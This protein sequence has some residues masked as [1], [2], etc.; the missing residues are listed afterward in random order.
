MCSGGGGV[1]RVA[2][3]RTGRANTCKT[4]DQRLAGTECVCGT[5]THT[6]PFSVGWAGLTFDCD[7]GKGL[8]ID[9]AVHFAEVALADAL[10]LLERDVGRC[11]G[12]GRPRLVL[13]LVRG[14]SRG[15]G[16]AAGKEKLGDH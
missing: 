16:S 12:H 5:H 4:L 9:A 7:R 15:P 3:T 1:S 6:R 14:W 11:R 2:T 13:V 8:Y 10:E